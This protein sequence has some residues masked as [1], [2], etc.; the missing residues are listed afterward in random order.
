VLA[1]MLCG[2]IGLH[3]RQGHGFVKQISS[4]SFAKSKVFYLEMLYGTAEAV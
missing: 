2:D 1:V 4:I 3:P